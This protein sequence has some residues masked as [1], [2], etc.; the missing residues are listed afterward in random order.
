VNRP[1]TVRIA[2]AKI[3]ITGRKVVTT[4]TIHAL[5]SLPILARSGKSEP[6]GERSTPTSAFPDRTNPYSEPSREG[7]ATHVR[8][9]STRPTDQMRRTSSAQYPTRASVFRATVV[10]GSPPEQVIQRSS[11]AGGVAWG[12]FQVRRKHQSGEHF[13]RMSPSPTPF[14]CRNLSDNRKATGRLRV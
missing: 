11:T 14:G 5:R 12:R 3:A 8:S 2:M 10:D 9:G 6:A 1:R 13:V 4:L 7:Y